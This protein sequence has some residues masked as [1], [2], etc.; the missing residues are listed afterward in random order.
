MP[1]HRSRRYRFVDDSESSVSSSCN[2]A[3]EEDASSTGSDSDS[4]SSEDESCEY[5]SEKESDV[6]SATR[7]QH[8][9]YRENGSFS[10]SDNESVSNSSLEDDNN[11]EGNSDDENDSVKE[12]DGSAKQLYLEEKRRGSVLKEKVH[13]HVPLLRAMAVGLKDDVR[14]DERFK[15]CVD[16]GFVKKKDVEMRKRHLYTEA[17]RRSS[18]SL[19]A[20]SSWTVPELIDHLKNKKNRVDE[21]DEKFIAKTI[22]S[23]LKKAEKSPPTWY[24]S[25]NNKG[26]GYTVLYNL[27]MK[28]EDSHIFKKPIKVVWESSEVFHCYPFPL[29]EQYFKNMKALTKKALIAYDLE[30]YPLFDVDRSDVSK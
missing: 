20:L 21:K 11:D 13:E 15:S 14:Q 27:M 19:K 28:C 18:S 24:V 29:F 2:S 25:A 1:R 23:V 8:N 3:C 9:H 10:S 26:V 16:T 6:E 17:K 7:N 30:D 5:Y 22:D 4:S 12:T